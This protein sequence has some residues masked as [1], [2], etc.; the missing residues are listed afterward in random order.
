MTIKMIRINGLQLE[1]FETGDPT[2]ETIVF[3]HGLGGN[4][5]QWSEQF[6][7]FKNYHV[8]SFS[9]QGHGESD[10]SNEY[11]IRSYYNSV[12]GILK[13]LSVTSCIWIGNSM[14]G[15]LGYEV[16]RQQPG[17]ITHLITNGT[18]PRLMMNKSILRLM[19]YMDKLLIK[20]MKFDG[21]IKFAANHSSDYDH[22]NKLV[23]DLFKMATPETIIT[24]HQVLGHYDYLD[25]MNSSTSITIIE[26]PNDKDINRYLKK[27]E[28][29]LDASNI[30]RVMFA[31]TGH[32]CNLEK[33]KAYNELIESIIQDNMI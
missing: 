26:S 13:H 1:V 18:T 11:S 2:K 30:E 14:G 9:L 7:Y 21:Y 27:C 25:C 10:N 24:S 23:Y 22:A 20:L 3:A 17:F 16:M 28:S 19:Y 4:L 29:S 8:V 32:I 33:P 6:N 5:R 12:N 15:V 31:K